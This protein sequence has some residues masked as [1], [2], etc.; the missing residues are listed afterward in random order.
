M[1]RILYLTLSTSFIQ[2]TPGVFDVTGLGLTGTLPPFTSPNL[3][4]LDVSNNTLSGNLDGTNWSNLKNLQTLVLGG[5]PIVGTIPSS[6][7]G[8]ELLTLADFTNMG[9]TGSMPA[10]VCA[11]R[12]INGGELVDLQADCSGTPPKV[13]CALVTCCTFCQ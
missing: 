9:L 4:Y 12:N 8:N 13:T 1:A 6:I 11:N 5:N 3:L 7:G 10:E 2:N